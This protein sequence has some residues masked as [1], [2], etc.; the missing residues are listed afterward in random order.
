MVEGDS[1]SSIEFVNN[2]NGLIEQAM[3][4]K[5]DDLQ[6]LSASS[7]IPLDFLGATMSH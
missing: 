1:D 5:Q 7:K 6:D 4:S 3:R 2:V